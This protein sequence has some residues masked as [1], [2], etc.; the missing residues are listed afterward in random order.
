MFPFHTPTQLTWRL[1]LGTVLTACALDFVTTPASA[2]TD[3]GETPRE[4]VSQANST[5]YRHLYR[6][7]SP[8][9]QLAAAI[10]EYME[11]HNYRIDRNP[12]EINIV[13]IKGMNPDGTP[14]GNAP[15]PPRYNDL[16]V[17]LT[18]DEGSR[19]QIRLAVPITTESNARLDVHPDHEPFG[20]PAQLMTGQHIGKWRLQPGMRLRR[21]RPFTGLMQV[22]ELPIGFDRNHNG[23]I[24][25]GETVR[26]WLPGRD[27]GAFVFHPDMNFPLSGTA[28]S[29]CIVTHYDNDFFTFIRY[30]EQSPQYRSNPEYRWTVTLLEP[31]AIL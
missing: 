28:S 22:G 10:V 15:L 16:L 31:N 17:L 12:G 21:G 9:S 7:P 14:N 19:P 13:L 29:G 20:G 5:R 24:D 1:L 30:L 26:Q 2:Q 25:P 23:H 8:R 4:A 11:S 18:F 27:G 3:S 6:R